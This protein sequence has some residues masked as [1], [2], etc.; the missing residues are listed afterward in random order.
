[1]SLGAGSL[2]VRCLIAWLRERARLARRVRCILGRV[3]QWR[4]AVQLA[5]RELVGRA[6]A[7]QILALRGLG[8]WEGNPPDMRGS[9]MSGTYRIA[10]D[11]LRSVPAPVACICAGASRRDQPQLPIRTEL[12][13]FISSPAPPVAA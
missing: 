11:A 8:A 9:E 4:R 12:K 5:L 6:R 7:R 13:P 1:M 3:R 10:K 2:P